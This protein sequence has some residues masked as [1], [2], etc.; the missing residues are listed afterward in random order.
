MVTAV[1]YLSAN[2][3]VGCGGRGCVYSS[4]C[5]QC[6]SQAWLAQGK[7]VPGTGS[8]PPCWLQPPTSVHLQAE[9]RCTVSPTACVG[10]Q[11]VP[12][13]DTH[14]LGDLR[15]RLLVSDGFLPGELVLSREWKFG[16]VCGGGAG[17][18]G[19]AG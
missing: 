16:S 8:R 2:Q 13:C 3:A 17:F 5:P 1:R 9:A 14:T 12:A 15:S 6:P 10:P 11:M 18:G 4:L 19:G 7:L